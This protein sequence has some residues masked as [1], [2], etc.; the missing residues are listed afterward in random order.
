MKRIVIGFCMVIVML[1]PAYTEVTGEPSAQG[2]S[3]TEASAPAVRSLRLGMSVDQLVGLFPGSAKRKEIKEALEKVKASTSNEPMMLAFDPAA[4]AA[5]QA[6]AGVDSV[7]ASVYK[8]RVIAFNVVYVGTTW[9]TIDE[10][11]EKVAQTYGLPAAA[12][13]EAGPNENPNRVLGCSGI[14]IEAAIQGGGSSIRVRNKDALKGMSERLNAA[15]ES[16]RREF[17]P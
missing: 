13:W 4:D 9:R 3:L 16:K 17:K 5:G 10:W 15:D 12:R 1:I 8:G 14:E 11:V 7:S 6:F 2:C